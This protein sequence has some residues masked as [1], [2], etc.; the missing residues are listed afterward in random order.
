MTL[1][2]VRLELARTPEFPEGNPHCGYEFIAPLD[3]GG[4]LDE[5][6]WSDSKAQCTV[7]RFWTDG[8]DQH[9]KLVR[10]HGHWMFSYHPAEHEVQEPIFRLDKHSFRPGD[11]VSVTEHDG[12]TYP[13]QV[14][15]VRPL[16]GAKSP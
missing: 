14:K 10:N 6:H 2:K 13:F 4:K 15:T 7:R 12:Q 9:G 5:T 16:I 1:Q 8:D 11:Y 3:A